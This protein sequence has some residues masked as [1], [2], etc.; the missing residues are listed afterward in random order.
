MNE[1]MVFIRIQLT[2]SV[3]VCFVARREFCEKTH[4]IGGAIGF[5]KITSFHARR[6]EDLPP[7]STSLYTLLVGALSVSMA[8]WGEGDWVI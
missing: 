6:E 3:C 4:G 2:V 8:G 5:F 1:R 7:V